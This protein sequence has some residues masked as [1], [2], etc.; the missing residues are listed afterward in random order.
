MPDPDWSGKAVKQH[1]QVG[2]RRGYNFEALFDFCHY[3]L[4]Y[5]LL[6]LF[7]E[8]CIDNGP[9]WTLDNAILE[10]HFHCTLFSR[11][12]VLVLDKNSIAHQFKNLVPEDKD[13]IMFAITDVSLAKAGQQV[14]MVIVLKRKILKELL[15]TYLPYTYT[16]SAAL[17]GSGKRSRQ[18]L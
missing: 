12:Q 10:K 8:V 13:L 15:T 9:F 4:F 11:Y 17:S 6:Y 1:S 3:F 16:L 7:M 5:G 14:K 2:Q 18:S